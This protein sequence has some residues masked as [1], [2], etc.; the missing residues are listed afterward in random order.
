MDY[1]LKMNRT[2]NYTRYAHQMSQ[3]ML[4]LGLNVEAGKALLLHANLLAWDDTKLTDFRNENKEVFPPQKSM[5]R[6]ERLYVQAMQMFDKA[7]YWEGSLKL[8][9]ELNTF[10]INGLYDYEKVSNTLKKMADYYRSIEK[11]DRFY[12][13]TFR[14]GYYGDFGPEFKNCDFIYRGEVLES[15][16][17]FT[18]RIKGKFPAATMLGVKV[19]AGPEHK[20]NTSGEQ[21]LQISKVTPITVESGWG[22]GGGWVVGVVPRYARDFEGNN[23]VS[24]FYYSRPFRKK[25][26]K[27]ENEFLDLWVEKK[28]LTVEEVLPNTQRRSKVV[29]VENIVVNPL[30]N[31]VA[32]IV[33]KNFELR[34]KFGAMK[35]LQDGAADNSYTMALNGVVDAAVN[36]GIGNYRTFINGQ[37]KDKNPEIYS[38]VCSSPSK[39]DVCDRLI[40]ALKEQLEILE[41]GVEIH[42]RKCSESLKPL[43]EHIVGMFGKMKV[44]TQEMLGEK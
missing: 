26:E 10:Y 22:R 31:A 43:H 40:K 6:K 1:L 28:V 44:D 25:K 12:P 32:E 29:K 36:G 35:N 24:Q 30:E 15:I 9:K 33:K 39:S 37:Y 21:Y 41:V 18:N 11:T 5:Q 7:Q 23:E 16:G 3:E 34:E 38:D 17:D 2:E 14:V 13:S 27:S 42:G 4:G 19:D 20:D 8:C